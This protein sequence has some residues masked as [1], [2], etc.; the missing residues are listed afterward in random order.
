[1][2]F[3]NFFFLFVVACYI[4]NR[5]CNLIEYYI[6][7]NKNE[8]S[9]ETCYNFPSLMTLLVIENWKNSN[10]KRSDNH[11]NFEFNTQNIKK[12]N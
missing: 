10:F 5:N 6:I 2:C 3:N 8:K 4:L 7:K 9:R 12:D 1:M 11:M